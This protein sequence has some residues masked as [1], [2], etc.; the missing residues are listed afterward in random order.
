MGIGLMLLKIEKSQLK[1]IY[2]QLNNM[3]V[4]C[5]PGCTL[6]VLAFPAH[7]SYTR[8]GFFTTIPNAE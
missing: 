2:C 3:G 7:N 6:Q 8:C 1:T 4:T 5:G